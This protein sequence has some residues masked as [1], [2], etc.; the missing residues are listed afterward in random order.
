GHAHAAAA[1]ALAA[2]G[3]LRVA[4]A[5]IEEIG[6]QVGAGVAARHLR[7]GARE[8]AD[9]LLAEALA[10]AGM[11]AGAAVHVVLQY[12]DAM[13]PAH[14]AAGGTYAGAGEAVGAVAANVGAGAAIEVVGER[15]DAQAGA[16][17]QAGAAVGHARAGD[18]ELARG[19]GAAA[20]AAVQH[21]HL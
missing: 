3:T 21:V 10:R 19:A 16:G 14:R 18:A 2:N 4:G 5:A 6:G 7:R 20:A 13:S 15:I 11:I 17:D 1:A 8:A 12:V 9:A